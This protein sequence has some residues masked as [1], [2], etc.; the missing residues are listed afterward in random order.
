MLVA[1]YGYAQS[2]KARLHGYALDSTKSLKTIENS[3]WR[4]RDSNPGP[5]D[6]DGFWLQKKL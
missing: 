2:P 1:S 3:W 6:Y 4:I 5:A